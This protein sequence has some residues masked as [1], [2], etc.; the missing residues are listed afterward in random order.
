MKKI[1]TNIAKNH[2]KI[3]NFI[4]IILY[5]LNLLPKEFEG[6]VRSIYLTKKYN[7]QF[8]KLS[9][10]YDKAG[11]YSLNPMPSEDFLK[12]YYKDTYWPS[13]TDKNYPIR[14]RDIEHYKFLIKKY[15]ILMISQ[16]KF[17]ILGQVME[18]YLFFFTY[19]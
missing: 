15:Q 6:R 3:R 17:L 14:L 7:K 2:D 13:R 11:F 19:S 12:K 1:I 5:K 4:A 16:K 18:V 8:K 10:N 9:L